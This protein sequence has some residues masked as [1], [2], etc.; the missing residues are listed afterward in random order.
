MRDSLDRPHLLTRRAALR[1]LGLGAAS[2]G[3]AACAPAAPSAPAKPT[4]A[5]KPAAPVA[6]AASPG[7]SPG[8]SPAASPGAAAPASK[9]S[10]GEAKIGLSSEPN[11]FDP[12]LTVG[13]NTQVFVVNV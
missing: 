1:S 5:T 12:H 6:P 4:E 9:P 13:R 8:A 10:A 11:T 3:L 7:A 2:I